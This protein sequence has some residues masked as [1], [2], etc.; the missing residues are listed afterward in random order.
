MLLKTLLVRNFRNLAETELE[1]S[2][3][4]NVIW[5]NNAQGKTNLLEAIYLL[6]HLKSFRNARG[7]D[8]IA[9]SAE[10]ARI[11]ACRQRQHRCQHHCPCKIG[12][13]IVPCVLWVII[14]LACAFV[15]TGELTRESVAASRLRHR[16]N[17]ATATRTDR[18]PRPRCA[19]VSGSVP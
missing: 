17:S 3:G 9:H 4:F 5:G 7:G 15:S 18:L 6:G 12:H 16:P 14:G 11:G 8:F 13:F 1:W 10:A 2:P 19:P